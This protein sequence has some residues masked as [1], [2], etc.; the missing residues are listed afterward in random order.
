MKKGK[1]VK[2]GFKKEGSQV[3]GNQSGTGR[4]AVLWGR[5]C[6][7]GNKVLE[8]ACWG[9]NRQTA[10]RQ[11]EGGLGGFCLFVSVLFVCL[12]VVFWLLSW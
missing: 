7:K 9:V 11:Q 1:Q 3:D 8:T 10:K 12:F 4:K 2:C 5:R 6:W